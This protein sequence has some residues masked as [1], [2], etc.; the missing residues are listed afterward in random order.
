MTPDPRAHHLR[1]RAQHLRRLADAIEATPAMSLERF[2][3]DDTWAG[4]RPHLCRTLLANG[5]QRLHAA[6]DDLRMHAHRL[7]R[8]ADDLEV[9]SR[10][11]GS[12]AG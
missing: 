11:A 2:A 4:A 8:D 6:A 7:D 5:Q 3:A 1:R 9:I 12:P 10:A